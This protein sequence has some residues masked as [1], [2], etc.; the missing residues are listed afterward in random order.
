MSQNTS[1][2]FIYAYALIGCY[3]FKPSFLRQLA[4]IFQFIR[5]LLT[6]GILLPCILHWQATFM[7]PEITS[8]EFPFVV[9]A[10]LILNIFTAVVVRMLLDYAWVCYSCGAYDT[11]KFKRDANFVRG[12]R[13]SWYPKPS[14]KRC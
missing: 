11:G 7:F 9:I 2:L 14:K 12:W 10:F 4:Y 13:W 5:I 6:F 1:A 3:I 8:T